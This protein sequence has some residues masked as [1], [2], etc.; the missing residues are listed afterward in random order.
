ML[1][2]VLWHTERTEAVY[3]DVFAGSVAGSWATALGISCLRRSR[4]PR[5]QMQRHLA[6]YARKLQLEH[7]DPRPTPRGP[8][9][10]VRVGHLLEFHCSF[11]GF[12]MHRSMYYVVANILRPLTSPPRLSYA[13]LAGP[14]QLDWFVS[15]FWGHAFCHF[16]SS[17]R[18]HAEVVAKGAEWQTQGYWICSFSNNQHRITEELGDSWRDSSFYAA[19]RNGRCKGTCLVIDEQASPLARSWCLFEL[20]QTMELEE[21]QPETFEGLS[22]CTHTGVMNLGLASVEMSIGVAKRLAS[23]RLEDASASDPKDKADID[24]LV[25][26]EMGGFARMNAA[27]RLRI[28]A[29]LRSARTAALQDFDKVEVELCHGQGFDREGGCAPNN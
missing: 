8:G 12:I 21:I 10:A 3:I 14:C 13:E 2:S 7:P 23:L 15:H 1:G 19:L 29:A 5:T 22:F 17:I 25:E 6:G 28:I 24:S 26:S 9:R 18:K 20:V 16:C 4:R 27:I 11:Q